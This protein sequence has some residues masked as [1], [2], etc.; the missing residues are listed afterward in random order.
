MNPQE[1][2][3]LASS[4]W[5]DASARSWSSR[6]A[7]SVATLLPI[8]AV[9][10]VAFLIIGVAMPVLPMHVH[11]GLG[12]GM[13]FVG[14]VAGG[15]FAAS[16]ISRLWAG[17]YSDSRGAKNAVVAGLLLASVAGVLYLFSLRFVAELEISVTLLL[18]GRALLGAG[19]SFVITG[20]Q[21]CA[22]ARSRPSS[23]CSSSR[24]GGRSGLPSPRSLSLSSWRVWSS[25]ICRTGLAAPRSRWL[26]Y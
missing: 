17:R 6:P 19:E 4:G 25:A 14:L 11:Q 16:L 20:A 7:N 18:L 13:L 10:F 21:S 8:M 2:V 12:L 23:R 15:Q 9:V 3:V 1:N 24:A 22:C 26:A 5:G